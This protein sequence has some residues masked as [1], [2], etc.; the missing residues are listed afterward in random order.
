MRKVSGF[1][2]IEYGLL[3]P[4][5]YMLYTFLIYVAIYQY[6]QC[7]L[8][9]DSCFVALGQQ[10]IVYENKY[11][12]A[13]DIQIDYTHKGNELYVKG[14]GSMS[15]PLFFIGIGEKNW[16][17]QSEVEAEVYAPTKILRFFK[18]MKY[19]G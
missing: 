10:T 17:L 1:V 16:Y 18:G 9:T 4:L 14:K 15:S 3:I 7:L 8:Q 19:G 12:L 5:L 11:L 6:N 2:T 13:E